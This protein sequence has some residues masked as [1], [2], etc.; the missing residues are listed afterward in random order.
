MEYKKASLDLETFDLEA[1]PLMNYN[2]SSN[3]LK[4]RGTNKTKPKRSKNN[5]QHYSRKQN[6]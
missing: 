2:Y 4:K 5:Q 1:N 6:R 3:Y